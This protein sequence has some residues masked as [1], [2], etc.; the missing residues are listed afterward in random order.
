MSKLKVAV[1]VGS[2]RRESINRKLAE[3]LVRLVGDRMEPHFVPIDDLPMYN[4]DLEGARPQAVNRFTQQIAAADALLFVTPEHNRSLPAV[5][6]NAIDWGSK[7]MDRNVWK[8]KV[9]AITG[10]SPSAIGTAVGQQHLRQVLGILGSL[11]IGGEAYISF[12]PDLMD[13]AGD[14]AN[15][16]TRTFLLAYMDAYLALAAKVVG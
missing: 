11:V 13:E 7:P 14:I 12:K 16:S 15:A 8:G 6:K 1:I 5:L 9:V 3:A 2:S 10:T 4:Q